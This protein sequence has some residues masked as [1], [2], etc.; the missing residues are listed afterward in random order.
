M[1]W[2]PVGLFEPSQSREPVRQIE[3]NQ[4][5]LILEMAQFSTPLHSLLHIL[6]IFI[7]IFIFT[8]Y[9]MSESYIYQVYT[10]YT[11]AAKHQ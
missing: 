4:D 2:Y 8:T 11:K 9:F 6:Y 5:T 10:V 1:V 3:S 7:F